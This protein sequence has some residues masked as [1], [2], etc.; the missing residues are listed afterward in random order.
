MRTRIKNGDTW[1]PLTEATF[2]MDAARAGPSNLVVSEFHYHP[3]DPTPEEAARGFNDGN[4]FEFIELMN[5]S[6]TQ[7]VDTLLSQT[8]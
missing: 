1:S 2:V 8:N 5:I 6:R 7:T 3:P 4:D